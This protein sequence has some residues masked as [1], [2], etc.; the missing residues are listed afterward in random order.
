MA[1]TYINLHYTV[2]LF[3]VRSMIWSVARQP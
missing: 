3:G 2:L 1:E